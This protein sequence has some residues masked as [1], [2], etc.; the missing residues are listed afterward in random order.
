M[1]EGERK[2]VLPERATLRGKN[3]T[4]RLVRAVTRESEKT[5]R[6]RS[7]DRRDSLRTRRELCDKEELEGGRR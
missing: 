2:A 7:R 6:P 3:G 4:R 1:G 5:G